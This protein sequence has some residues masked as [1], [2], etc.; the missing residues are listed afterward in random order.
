[1]TILAAGHVD[2]A[3]FVASALAGVTGVAI[4]EAPMP[5]RPPVGP[6]ALIQTPEAV[7]VRGLGPCEYRFRVSVVVI[8]KD[9]GGQG[10]LEATD[11]VCDALAAVGVQTA[12]TGMQYTPSP[13]SPAAIPAVLITGN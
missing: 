4:H 8:G 12:T 5:D 11:E 9:S 3:G 2:A 6:A 7:E 1:V 10:L 13:T